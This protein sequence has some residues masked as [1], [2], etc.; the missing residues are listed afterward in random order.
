MKSLCVSDLSWT[1]VVAAV[2]FCSV[3]SLVEIIVVVV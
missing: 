2:V 3:I 1:D